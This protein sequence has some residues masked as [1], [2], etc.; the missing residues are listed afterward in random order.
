MTRP[1]QE[2]PCPIA[3][4]FLTWCEDER[5]PANTVKRRRSVL[6]SVGN[7]GT[8][9]R[10]EVEEWWTTRRHLKKSTRANDLAVLRSFYKWCQRWDHRLDDPTVR[11]DAPKAGTGAPKPITSAQLGRV[12]AHLAAIEEP[13]LR[14]AVLLGAGAGLRISE[15]AALDWADLDVD[16]RTIRIHGKGDK[17]RL[18]TISKR[19][20]ADLVPA[21]DDT[22]PGE[23]LE[24]PAAGNVVTGRPAGWAA[25]T[26]GAKVNTAI[27]AAGVDA[28]FHK[29]R[30]QY[31]SLA[32]QRSK[33]PKAVA[34]QMG[35][36]S[37]ATTMS[38]YARAADDAAAA[39]ADAVTDDW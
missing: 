24:P 38:Y 29:L 37:V 31:G 7:P 13:A 35:H 11:L 36:A 9:T 39:I 28:T 8:A 5:L 10:E 6:R 17:T 15:A 25:S 3:V 34:D 20:L 22:E 30:H 14:R 23:E 12:L 16:A 21:V 27:R 2:V 1:V 32:Y 4:T 19:L 18:V 26:L 33:D